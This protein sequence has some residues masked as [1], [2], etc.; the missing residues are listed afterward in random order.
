[1]NWNIFQWRSLKTRVT[2]FTLAIFVISIWVLAFY[3]SRMLREDMQRLLSD[4]Q[5]STASFVAEEVDEELDNRVKGLES[6]AG[7]VSPAMLGDSLALQKFL[8]DRPVLQNMFN[9]GLL[10][11]GL[12]GTAIA[13]VPLAAGRIGVNYADSD[14]VAAA[15]EE[16]K[17]AIGR[18]VIGKKL[19]TPLFVIAAPIRDS[20]AKVIGALI[21]ATDLSR[22]N[23]L[24]KLTDSH[25]GKTG[26]YLLI[27][28]RLII[29]ATDKSR[30]MQPLPPSGINPEMDR[31]VQGYEGSGVYVNSIGV[32][33]LNSVK[34][35]PMAGWRLAVNLPTEEAFAPINAMQRRILLVTIFLTLLAGLVTWW[36]LRRQLSPMLAAVRALATMS[37]ANQP[38]PPLPIASQ[39]EIGQ[40]IGGFNRLLETLGQREEALKE[41]EAF[42]Q[43]VLDSVAAEIVVLDRDGVILAVN[44][45]WRRF[46]LHNGVE[47]GKPVPS[48]DVGINYLGTCQAG[49]GF[50]TDSAALEARDGIR[51]V[52]DGRLPSFSLEYPCHS[53]KQQRWFSMSTMPL[54][55]VVQGGV[56]ITHTDI[57]ERKIAEMELQT[58]NRD[59]VTMLENTSDFIY[60]KDRDSRMRF[61]SQVMANI[62]GHQSWRDMVGKHDLEIFPEDTARIYYE[63]ELPV[64]RDGTAILNR[65]D[66]YYDAQGNPRWVSTNKWPVFAEDGK[67][68]IGL[69][70]IS[71]DITQRKQAEDRLTE[72]NLILEQRVVDRT[73]ALTI[74]NAKMEDFATRLQAM[75]RRHAGA[76][77]AERRRLARELHDRVS[78]SLT[79]IGLGL[80]LIAKQLPRDAGDDIGVRLSD[81]RAMLKDTAVIAREI[82]HDLHPSVLEYGGVL[83][84]LEEYGRKFF[85]QTGIAIQVTGKDRGVRLLPETEIALYRIAQEALTNCA[86]YAN[87]GI[88]TI[89]LNGDVEHLTFVIS[90]NGVGFDLKMLTNGN[91]APGLGL[92]SMRERAEA[93]GGTLTLESAPGL[94]TRITVEISDLAVDYPGAIDP[95]WTSGQQTLL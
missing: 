86:K 27:Q 72:L 39:D 37:D 3:V 43:A 84:A 92:L 93:I 54:A 82:S 19:R 69:F 77:E 46:A 12:D 10:V 81:T 32:E 42:K 63:E 59:F 79:A 24:G 45:L 28:D 52:L 55:E 67:T 5:F 41:S 34:A 60:F 70:G 36:M 76:E 14:A 62:T 18:P 80:D 17:S 78:S 73:N 7:R 13:D 26:G 48:T 35:V 44:E 23:F 56:V 61:C 47:P 57:T 16:G 8:E 95:P 50:E 33:I 91:N 49:I 30:I 58:L 51:G 11:V 88:V 15:L 83:P 94:G 2:L 66:P 71:R 4:Q 31:F 25:Y 74:A 64:F 68:V 38:L 89:A 9:G 75:T 53:P 29:T 65:I 87:A 90:D 20:Q 6:V 21:G 22:P 40:L 85:S 1:M